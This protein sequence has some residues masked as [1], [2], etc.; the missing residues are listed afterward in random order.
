MR[1]E[2]IA[3]L[4]RSTCGDPRAAAGNRQSRSARAPP[5]GALAPPSR[6][7]AR[8][9]RAEATA[10]FTAL[11]EHHGGNLHAALKLV[12]S[13]E[14]QV[15]LAK[16]PT[17]APPSTPRREARVQQRAERWR[18]VRR[19]RGL[20]P[21]CAKLGKVQWWSIDD[22]QRNTGV[23]LIMVFAGAHERL[24]GA[25]ALL[26]GAAEHVRRLF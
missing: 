18:W 17:F 20:L 6:G 15:A 13:L 11:V 2:S 4:V 10:L 7:N 24:F 26:Y 21:A 14:L 8:Q 9:V 5:E 16:V 19:E 23:L 12:R 25:T 3:A 22:E 1:D